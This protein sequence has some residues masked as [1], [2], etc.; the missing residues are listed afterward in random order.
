M[1]KNGFTLI[2]F[3]IIGLIVGII[4]GQL[5]APV[6]ALSF[7]TQSTSIVWQPRADL[8][9]I[10]YDINLQIKLNLCSI[11]G[12]AAAFWLYRKV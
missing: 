2:L 11:L 6:K 10:S 4:T 1:K 7:L 12:L 9:V 5:L 3:L 8:Q